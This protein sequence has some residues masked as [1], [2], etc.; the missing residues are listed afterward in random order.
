MERKDY[1]NISVVVIGRNE[2][3]MIGRCL[4][5][6]LASEYPPGKLEVIYVDSGSSDRT[7]EVASG[8]PVRILRIDPEG[9][10]PASARN[11]GL[12]QASGEFVQF[13]DGDMI[14]HP[15]WLIQAL[16]YFEDQ[17]VACVVGEVRELEPQ[18]SM[19]NR[20]LDLSWKTREFG[21]ISS[22]WGGGLFRRRVLL[23]IGGYDPT[24]V[25]AEEIELGYRLRRRGYKILSIPS[26]MA[27]HNANI[28][29]FK[30]F[31]RRCLRDGYGEMQ[32][33][34]RCQGFR[35]KMSRRYTLLSNLQ[36]G[37][38]LSSILAASAMKFYWGMGIVL[39]TPWVLILRKTLHY[40]KFN[41]SLKD[42]FFYSVFLY[43]SK[44]PMSLGQI[45]GLCCLGGRSIWR[46]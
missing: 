18:K 30:E 35:E 22:P 37:L 20:W 31:W 6:I 8:Y 25:T 24:L 38:F 17:E 29:H 32:V 46:E 21:F 39:L 27:Y 3:R 15:K 9:A 2:E 23:E 42:S 5:S 40:H 19:Y 1:P 45:K 14:L 10:N 4:G 16:K 41:K 28:R 33:L 13:V 44:I 12:R 26:P 34:R 7:V 43:L 36:I 11:E